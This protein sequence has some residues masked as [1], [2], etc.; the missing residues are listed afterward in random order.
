MFADQ[1]LFREI[2]SE[3][4]TCNQ[5]TLNVMI[6]VMIRLFEVEP[7][8]PNTG[9]IRPSTAYFTIIYCAECFTM[10]TKRALKFYASATT[11]IGFCGVE[12]SRKYS[13]RI[14]QFKCNTR[15]FEKER[16]KNSERGNNR[17]IFCQRRPNSL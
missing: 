8:Y 10:N 1:V 13:S 7:E 15:I 11:C 2:M 6:R 3:R 17:W 12:K 4:V 9:Y 14:D 5:L 16:A